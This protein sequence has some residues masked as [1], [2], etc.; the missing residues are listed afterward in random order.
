MVRFERTTERGQRRLTDEPFYTVQNPDGGTWVGFYRRGT[1]YLLRFPG[2]AD[3]EVTEDGRGVRCRPV[4]GTTKSTVE[5]LFNNQVLPLALSQQGCLVLH[6][7]AV[8]GEGG[9]LAFLGASGRGKSTLAAS[10]AVAGHRLLTD[11]LLELEPSEHAIS[12]CPGHRSIRLWDDS[13]AALFGAEP[14]PMA[15]P[16][17]FTSKARFL[18]G[19]VLAFH[20]APQPLRCVFFLGDTEVRAPIIEPL[21]GRDILIELA[22]NAFLLDMAESSRVAA[23]FRQLS[24]VARLPIYYRLDYPRRF[25][26][27]PAVRKAIVDHANRQPEVT[28]TSPRGDDRPA[29]PI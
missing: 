2:L 23:H 7:S 10:F 12:A 28:S 1:D 8:E 3:F 15:P 18:A 25:D 24:Q 27:L 11:D 20:V 13:R 6:G 16:V 14:M 9:G 5:H 22:K 29:P 19:G 21:N 26:A 4:P 17:E